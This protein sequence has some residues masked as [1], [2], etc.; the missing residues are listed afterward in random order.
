[1]TIFNIDESQK[2]EKNVDEQVLLSEEPVFLKQVD[3]IFRQNSRRQ[4][5]KMTLQ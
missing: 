1:M 2:S 4:R 3:K 5:K